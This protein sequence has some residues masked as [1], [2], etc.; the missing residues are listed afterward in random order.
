MKKKLLLTIF[1]GFLSVV[2]LGGCTWFTPDP[3]TPDP[4]DPDNPSTDVEEPVKESFISYFDKSIIGT[5]WDEHTSYEDQTGVEM[6][7]DTLLNQQVDLLTQDIIYRLVSVYG[8]GMPAVNSALGEYGENMYVL[9]D[10]TTGQDYA[11]DGHKAG[12]SNYVL[13]DEPVSATSTTAT[14]SYTNGTQVKDG[15][16]TVAT[17]DASQ[18]ATYA[19][20]FRNG[21]WDAE[22][23]VAKQYRFTQAMNGGYTYSNNIFNSTLG[24]TSW[25]MDSSATLKASPDLSNPIVLYEDFYLEHAESI[26]LAIANIL[27]IG[28]RSGYSYENA[29]QHI[30]H[31]GFSSADKT[32]IKNYILNYVIGSSVVAADNAKAPTTTVSTSTVLSNDMHTYKAYSVIVPSM[33]EQAFANTFSETSSSIWVANVNRN[34][35]SS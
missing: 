13:I 17:I 6:S 4:D 15:A 32:N 19:Y 31:L 25:A 18:P 30:S 3:T 23:T 11:S 34:Y 9:T 22:T 28:S 29:I 14:Y 27:A 10:L 33:L 12:I 20:A 21:S 2:M 8:A 26:R 1:A 35:S 5:Y 7:F 16:T 24:N